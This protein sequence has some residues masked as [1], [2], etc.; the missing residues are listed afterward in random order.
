MKKK[1]IFFFISFTLITFVFLISKTQVKFK[2]FCLMLTEFSSQ[3]VDLNKLDYSIKKNIKKEINLI[4][5]NL[6]NFI[7]LGDF[8]VITSSA[9]NKCLN[10]VEFIN[11]KL[12]NLNKVFKENFTNIENYKIIVKSTKIDLTLLFLF[13]MFLLY[14]SMTIFLV[15]LFKLFFDKKNLK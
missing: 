15:Y 3:Q 8:R 6:N 12:N 10:D 5:K 2:N 14:L 7:R 1:L 9:N 11:Q 13:L 4:G